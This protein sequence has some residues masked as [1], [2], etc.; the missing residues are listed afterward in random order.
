MKIPKDFTEFKPINRS[1]FN[2]ETTQVAKE[3]LGQLLVRTVD[4]NLMVVRITE[5]EAY[6]G[7]ADPA[8]HAYRGKRGR[9]EI[10]FGDVGFAYV[11]LSYGVHYC[12]NVV[13]KSPSQEAGAVLLRSAEP[14]IGYQF[15]KKFH[16]KDACRISSG[17]GNLTR[18][19]NINYKYNGCDLTSCPDLFISPGWLNEGE[20]VVK[21][22]RV[23]I[24]KATDKKWRFL[25][26]DNCSVSKKP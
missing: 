11:Y 22:K 5:V 10:M 8:S 15:M 12:L 20:K 13:A 17:P 2:R 18:S 26:A 3:L 7:L 24:S 21:S 6:K 19:L 1:F 14:V 9:A 23:G 16:D 4:E 25:I